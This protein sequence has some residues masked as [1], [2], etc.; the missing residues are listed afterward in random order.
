[1]LSAALRLFL[2]LVINFLLVHLVAM[3]RWRLAIRHHLF[4]LLWMALKRMFLGVL[5]I[6]LRAWLLTRNTMGKGVGCRTRSISL[7]I[8]G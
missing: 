3:W 8:F 7:T 1:M 5:L 4:G 2:G 6:H